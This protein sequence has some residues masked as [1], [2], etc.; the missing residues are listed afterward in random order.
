MTREQ[1]KAVLGALRT[2]MDSPYLAYDDALSIIMKLED[3]DL[4]VDP[5]ALSE[6]VQP[7]LA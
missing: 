1:I 4:D 2:L 3:V 5:S 7:P 6:L